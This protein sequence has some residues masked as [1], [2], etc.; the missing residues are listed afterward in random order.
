MAASVLCVGFQEPELTDR[1]ASTLHTLQPGAVVLFARHTASFAQTRVLTDRL[2]SLLGDGVPPVIAVDQE[3]GRVARLRDEVDEIPA[4]MALRATGDVALA[5]RAGQRIALDLRRAGFNLNFGPVLDLALHQD[6]TVIGTRS[7]SDD[8]QM[9][10]RF[11]AAFAA[12]MEA[13][14]IVATFKHFPGHGST[15]GDSHQLLPQIDVDEAQLR[16]RDLIPFA[17]LLPKARAVMTAHIVVKALDAVNPATVSYAILTDLLRRQM[18]FEGV[19]FTDCMHMDAISNGIG[20]AEG[21]VQ[22]LAAGAD[23][24][25]ITQHIS[26][27]LQAVNH[28]VRA[29]ERE[30]LPFRRLEEAANR[31]RALRVGLQPPLD[32]PRAEP[33][34]G[35][36]IARR[37]FTQ[38]RGSAKLGSPLRIVSFQGSTFEGAFGK[39]DE[40]A[41]LANA[42]R[43]RGLDATTHDLALQPSYE[44]VRTVI[45]DLEAR[46]APVAILMRRAHIHE[47]QARAI[48]A[49]LRA[50]PDALLVS[51][52]EPFDVQLFPQAA[53]VACVYDDENV[54]IEA[55][56]GVLA[57]GERPVGTL[58]VRL[59]AGN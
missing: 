48:H 57:S 18:K 1:T 4:M 14:G 2:R 45:E 11:A 36:E 49:L 46:E 13:G 43:R 27:S 28:I 41:S 34:V 10:T 42:L 44:D 59:N 33:A 16:R 54:T 24:V 37:A 58:P 5:E 15:A 39:H 52:R 12:G 26:A 40:H 51:M 23:C 56:A 6:N 30:E 38:I 7:F 55:L 20:T 8:P 25:S 47:Q 31:M 35:P 3:G 53:H 32:V 50:F 17:A 22:A 29:V 19:C 9:V 21:A